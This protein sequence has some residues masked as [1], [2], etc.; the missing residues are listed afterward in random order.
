MD[1]LNA[2]VK[3]NKGE[4]LS[5]DQQYRCAQITYNTL[6]IRPPDQEFHTSL[7]AMSP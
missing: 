4:E 7:H 5:L 6:A 1:K 2:K 3:V